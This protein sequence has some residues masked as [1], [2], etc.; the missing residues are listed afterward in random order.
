M[1]EQ[2]ILHRIGEIDKMKSNEILNCNFQVL[3]SL[4]QQIAGQYDTDSFIALF[5]IKQSGGREHNLT[6]F[7]GGYDELLAQLKSDYPVLWTL[8]AIEKVERLQALASKKELRFIEDL[9]RGKEERIIEL[10]NFGVDNQ[11]FSNSH[12]VLD[13]KLAGFIE[14]Y[15]EGGHVGLLAHPDMEIIVLHDSHDKVFK[16]LMAKFPFYDKYFAIKRLSKSELLDT[17]EEDG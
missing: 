14:K 5:C 16:Y 15:G 6:I 2:T 3:H 10:P 9:R 11:L 12:L 13:A 8:F 17:E 4:A 1:D 7:R